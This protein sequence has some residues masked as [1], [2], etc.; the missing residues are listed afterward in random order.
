MVGGSEVVAGIVL[1]SSGMGR[2]PFWCMMIFRRALV[3]ASLL[4]DAI[5][6]LR[7]PPLDECH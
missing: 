5:L 4:V 1:M 6:R 3:L 2:H 7:L